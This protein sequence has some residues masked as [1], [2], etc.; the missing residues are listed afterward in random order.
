M[1]YNYNNI[2]DPISGTKLNTKSKKAKNIIKKYG[3]ILKKDQISINLEKSAI[4]SKKTSPLNKKSL[5]LSLSL[6]SSPDKNKNSKDDIKIVHI[7]NDNDDN[8]LKKSITT[9]LASTISS[10][11]NNNIQKLSNNDILE[12]LNLLADPS[13]ITKKVTGENIIENT[14]KT[15]VDTY[16]DKSIKDNCNKNPYNLDKSSYVASVSTYKSSNN[17]SYN[18][19]NESIKSLNWNKPVEEIKTKSIQHAGTREN[20]DIQ[21]DNHESSVDNHESSVDMSVSVDEKNITIPKLVKRIS[22]L[23]TEITKVKQ[24]FKNLAGDALKL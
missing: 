1:T 13:K 3:K 19:E 21:L 14:K 23:E 11:N 20:D 4:I 12:G 6:S 2:I 22:K 10:N 24:M 7:D 9:E 16:I 17:L 15:L 18:T 5:S 8:V